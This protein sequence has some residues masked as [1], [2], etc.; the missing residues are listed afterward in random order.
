MHIKL[1]VLTL[2]SS[3]LMHASSSSSS[4]AEGEPGESIFSS[5]SS[6][7]GG[8]AIYGQSSIQISNKIYRDAQTQ[9][10]ISGSND[11]LVKANII[12]MCSM[13]SVNALIIQNAHNALQN[14]EVNCQEGSADYLEALQDFQ[15]SL[16]NASYFMIDSSPSVGILHANGLIKKRIGSLN[17]AVKDEIR[18]A[19]KAEGILK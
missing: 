11:D 18:L 19:F 6:V 7:P 12:R 13:K 16:N 3:S 10:E 4:R 1:F 17:Y 5:S 8:P 2:L 14:I 15:K 9:T